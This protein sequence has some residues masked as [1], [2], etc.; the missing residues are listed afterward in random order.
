MKYCRKCGKKLSDDSVFCD[1]CGTKVDAAG[2]GIIHAGAQE[3]T[4]YKKEGSFSYLNGYRH[5]QELM[6]EIDRRIYDRDYDVAAQKMRSAA[7]LM[8]RDIYAKNGGANSSEL[9]FND[10]L[11]ALEKAAVITPNSLS[12]Y[13]LIRKY[14][15]NASHG[16]N[17]AI[18]DV[19]NMYNAL[20]QETVEYAGRYADSYSK[21][22]KSESGRS[23][24]P[25]FINRIYGIIAI[26]LGLFF[27]GL[28]ATISASFV[29]GGS[30]LLGIG[31]LLVFGVI[32]IYMV[33]LGIY[34]LIT[35][36]D[37]RKYMPNR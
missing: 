36:K 9:S 22:I 4:E 32:G 29:G 7:E 11:A 21:S 30:K 1:A 33:I 13:H 24:G 8:A 20:V 31:A 26:C 14:G 18:S 27:I 16:S 2:D 17:I 25:K 23:E 35:G 12:N 28:A 37:I 34:G 10:I 19:R 5:L 6:T 3:R 15:N